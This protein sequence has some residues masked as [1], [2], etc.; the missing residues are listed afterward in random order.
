M[1]RAVE[2][3]YL[4][5]ASPFLREAQKNLLCGEDEELISVGG[6]YSCVSKFSRTP[7]IWYEDFSFVPARPRAFP[8]I[9]AHEFFDAL[10][11]HSFRRAGADWREFLVNLPAS[12]KG[13]TESEDGV[14]KLTTSGNEPECGLKLSHIGTRASLLLSTISHRYS[15]YN[16]PVGT[17]IEVSLEA[18]ALMEKISRTIGTAGAGAALV[19]DYGT[20]DTVPSAS[21]RGIRGHKFCSPFRRPGSVDLSAD[22]D[23]AGLADAATYASGNVEVHGPVLQG[24]FLGMLGAKERVESLKA[25]IAKMGEEAWSRRQRANLEGDIKTA[26]EAESQIARSQGQIEAIDKSYKRLVN[27]SFGGMGKV[28]KALAVLPECGG[29]KPVG[30][31]GSVPEEPEEPKKEDDN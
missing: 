20:M 28:Y 4:I 26:E 12:R 7:I 11:I 19:I 31:G 10:P 21:L 16:H 27:G 18:L 13:W 15:R 24:A 25:P 5:E 9:I 6:G 23:F 17:T 2:T 8:F 22:V 30:F 29:R 3:V 14:S 1:S